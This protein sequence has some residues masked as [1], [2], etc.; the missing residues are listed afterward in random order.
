MRCI[1]VQRRG[2]LEAAGERGRRTPAR[3]TVNTALHG[4]R[5]V[6]ASGLLRAAK[7]KGGHSESNS[8]CSAST[9]TCTHTHARMHTAAPAPPPSCQGINGS[10]LKWCKKQIA[11]AVAFLQD[12]MWTMLFLQ[13]FC[14][15]SHHTGSSGK[16][17]KPELLSSSPRNYTNVPPLV[18]TE[19]SFIFEILTFDLLCYGF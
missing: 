8:Y 19:M 17:Q 14:P 15:A 18:A 2:G 13:K 12:F 5:A 9:A 4:A 7:G 11:K 3:H 10:G 16:C 6:W 1:T